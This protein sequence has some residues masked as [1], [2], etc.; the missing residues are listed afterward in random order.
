MLTVASNGKFSVTW[1]C[2]TSAIAVGK[3][4]LSCAYKAVGTSKGFIALICGVCS[5]AI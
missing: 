4:S 5:S 3:G 2:G 1:R